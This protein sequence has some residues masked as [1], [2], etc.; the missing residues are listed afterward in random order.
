MPTDAAKSRKAFDTANAGFEFT[1][2]ASLGQDV[3]W[4][5]TIDRSGLLRLVASGGGHLYVA[6]LKLEGPRR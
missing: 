2:V 4:E 3:P 6:V 5:G 1:A